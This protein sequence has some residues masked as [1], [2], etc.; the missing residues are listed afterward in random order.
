VETVRAQHEH[1]RPVIQEMVA[2]GTDYLKILDAI[3]VERA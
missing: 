3:E 2:L 1:I